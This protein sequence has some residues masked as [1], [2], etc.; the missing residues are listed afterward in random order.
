MANDTLDKAL[1]VNGL[2]Y[3]NK[4]GMLLKN[5]SFSISKGGLHAIL[6][7]LGSDSS[8][9]LDL[10]SGVVTSSSGSV[11]LLGDPISFTEVTWKKKIGYVPKFPEFYGTMTVYEV[12]D[13]VGDA[14]SVPLELR[15][16]QIEE[17]LELLDI[18]SLEHRLISSLSLGEKKRLG[19]AAALLG[20]PE[21]LLFDD[22]TTEFKPLLRMLGGL[23]T[24][25]LG[26]GDFEIM[27]EL[28]DDVVILSEGALIANGTFAELEDKL[29]NNGETLS[30]F[31]F[32]S[33]LVEVSRAALTSNRS[34]SVLLGEENQ[35]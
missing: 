23:K 24:V 21:I 28:C 33:S 16:R 20:N 25:I 14:R 35:Q 11:T 29:T 18:S 26:G 9:L 12:L 3:S 27:R 1:S 32:Y 17:A 2:S 4:Q 19:L 10:L 8:T 7:P 15:V 34:R 6:S 30:L 5:L 22:P 13:F 31:E